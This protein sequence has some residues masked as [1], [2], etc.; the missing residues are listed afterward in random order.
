MMHVV[1]MTRALGAL[2]TVKDAQPE[3]YRWTDGSMSYVDAEFNGGRLVRWQMIRSA[4]QLPI[5]ER[6][7][8]FSGR[9]WMEA[10]FLS[11]PM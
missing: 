7:F 8:T 11:I 6:L 10:R 1:A 4:S 3:I 5:C 9:S 2:Q